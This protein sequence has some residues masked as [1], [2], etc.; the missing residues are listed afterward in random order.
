M[1][2]VG[3]PRRRSC[4]DGTPWFADRATESE[5]GAAEDAAVTGL[6]DP[7][8]VIWL[9]NLLDYEAPQ[10][11]LLAYFFSSHRRFA[12]QTAEVLDRIGAIGMAHVVRRAEAAMVANASVW[13]ARHGQMD[14][15]GKMP[16]Y[17]LT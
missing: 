7:V 9:L 17:L 10:G 11:S 1:G 3:V 15:A 6:P 8:R 16:S 2:E 12:T 13:A 4:A 5:I 14:Q